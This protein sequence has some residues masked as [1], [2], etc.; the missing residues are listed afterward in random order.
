MTFD[1]NKFC[2]DFLLNAE[3]ACDR[4]GYARNILAGICAGGQPGRARLHVVNMV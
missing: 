2:M 3:I 1:P 4:W